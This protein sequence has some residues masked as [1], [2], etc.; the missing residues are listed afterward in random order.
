MIDGEAWGDNMDKF[1]SIDASYGYKI[2]PWGA[3]KEAALALNPF[4]A[5]EINSVCGVD[6]FPVIVARYS[7][8][9]Q[10]VKNGHFH[11]QQQERYL[12]L[13]HPAIS[14]EARELLDYYWRVIPFG[15]MLHNSVETHI[16]LPTHI[17]PY[18]LYQPG[19]TF[20]L[21]SIFEREGY[22]HIIPESYSITA[23][24]RS[25]ITLPQ[26]AHQQYHKR[27]SKRL[28]LQQVFNPRTFA[29]QWAFFK[30]ISQS[31]QFQYPWH[32]DII[33]FSRYFIEAFN[34]HPTLKNTLL[35]SIWQGTAFMRNQ[36]TYDLVWSTFIEGNLSLALKNSLAV[37]ETVRYLLR[38]IMQANGAY[39]PSTNDIAGP[40]EGFSKALL[41]IYRIRF[42]LPI[43]MQPQHYDNTQ[44]V[45]YSLQKPFFLHAI[46]TK[47]TTSQT[48][49]IM[50]Q[51]KSTFEAFKQQILQD[52]LPFSLK[53]T[54]LYHRLQETEVTFYHPKG[55]PELKEDI[56]T[57]FADDPRFGKIQQQF[58]H[59]HHLNLPDS[60]MFFHG[61]IRV[62]P[63]VSK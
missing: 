45:Y 53:G 61:C 7:F 8:G 25:L 20:S 48:I 26:I 43:F 1:A 57:I 46:P 35:Q 37:M 34:H 17:I 40:I 11:L 47:N 63:F 32:A 36:T 58:C 3:I 24:S 28:H 38:V 10:I 27:L 59:Y 39:A 51:I 49:N 4:I 41:D 19:C 2:K 30:A 22:S 60:S 31:K 18:R 55:G 13:D 54:L 16:E 9:S 50:K 29:E 44:P 56:E 52:Q 42:Y 62:R 14:N 33:F 6:E 21:L 23:G 5:R 12:P 15:M